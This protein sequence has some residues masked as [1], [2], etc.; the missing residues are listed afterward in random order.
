MMNNQPDIFCTHHW[1]I[2]TNGY[3]E[4]Q[5]AICLKC[6]ALKKFPSLDEQLL[7]VEFKEVIKGYTIDGA[8]RGGFAAQ[9]K[10]RLTVSV[11]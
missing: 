1:R 3:R 2:E 4:E 11:V 5:S 6:G 8:R 10:R 7:Q 9:E